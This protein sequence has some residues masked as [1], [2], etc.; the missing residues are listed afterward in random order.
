[1]QDFLFDILGKVIPV[2]VTVMLLIDNII[3]A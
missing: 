1:M 3:N 2:L